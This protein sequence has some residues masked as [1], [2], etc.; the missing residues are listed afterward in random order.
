METFI[1]QAERCWKGYKP[2]PGKKAYSKGSCAPIEKK[3][4]KE[5]TQAELIKL[6]LR[7]KHRREAAA[8]KPKSKPGMTKKAGDALGFG[9]SISA[10]TV[11]GGYNQ[12]VRAEDRARLLAKRAQK[13]P[14]FQ[15]LYAKLDKT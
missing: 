13:S 8:A 10:S 4:A 2:V 14:Y 15:R 5:K 11:I 1:K 9:R 12:N 7:V 6:M 3:A